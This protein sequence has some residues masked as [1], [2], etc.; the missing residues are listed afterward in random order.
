MPKAI[1]DIVKEQWIHN[2]Y[3]TAKKIC[4]KIVLDIEPNTRNLTE[5]TKLSYKQH[6]AYVNKLLSD[7]R[8]YQKQGYYPKQG[9]PQKPLNG[10]G[11]L[12]DGRLEKRT[13]MWECIERSGFVGGVDFKRG[14]VPVVD[15]VGRGWRVVQN[16]NNMW[17]FDGGF[18]HVHWYPKGLVLLYL[19]G[20]FSVNAVAL[21]KVKQLFCRAFFWLNGQDLKR[22]L[23]VP[24]REVSRK[25]IF[26]VGAIVPRFSIKHF[27][28]S[29][30]LTTFTDGSH[31]SCFVPGTLIVTKE[32]LENIEDITVGVEVLSHTGHWRK[33]THVMSRDYVGD[34]Y[35]V[36]PYNGLPIKGV[37][38]E[39]PVFATDYRSGMRVSR[40][41]HLDWMPVSQ[42]TKKH[43]LAFPMLSKHVIPITWVRFFGRGTNASKICSE[44]RSFFTASLYRL[45][46]YYIG[47]GSTNNKEIHIDFALGQDNYA[48][49]VKTIVEKQLKRKCR[50]YKNEE[51]HVTRVVFCHVALMRWLKEC[52]GLDAWSKTMPLHFLSL[53]IELKIELFRG[54]LGSDG[55]ICVVEGKYPRFSYT[56]VSRNLAIRVSMLLYS[57]GIIASIKKVKNKGYKKDGKDGFA[58]V[59]NV[60]GKSSS[61]LSNLLG[62]SLDFSKKNRTFQTAFFSGRE[63][64]RYVMHPIQSIKKNQYS[65]KVYNLEVEIDNSYTTP[66][67]IWHNCIHFLETVPF[68]IDEQKQVNELL[69]KNIDGLSGTVKEMGVEIREHLKL[70][71]AWQKQSVSAARQAVASERL[72]NRLSDILAPMLQRQVMIDN[73]NVRNQ[74]KLTDWG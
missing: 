70:I 74:R 3:I 12:C 72:I 35:E 30:G 41:R 22:F 23:D 31:P 39:H 13:F 9:L 53:P 47:D 62:L 43:Y 2:P 58:F 63:T 38:P 56:T 65:G 15:L 4:E 73:A 57:L 1:K 55:S 25:W 50:V 60:T 44:G 32:G 8:H 17:K 11:V 36:M 61:K 19:R 33:V 54:L 40:F 24:I 34:V 29:H 42:L 46:G 26:D 6:G 21:A 49:D 67:A 5:E 45:I 16:R 68:W 52:V 28:R 10:G 71:K 20:E 59:I 27:E 7:L 69:S 48:D 66:F 37:T 64:K 14:E 51:K 18:G